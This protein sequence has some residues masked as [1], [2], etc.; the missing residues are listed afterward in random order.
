[1][2]SISAMARIAGS[3]TQPS[4]SCARHKSEITA[5]AWRPSGYFA[6][7]F[8]AQARFSGVKAKLAGCFSAR[9]R[10]AH[11]RS[12]SPKTMSSEPRMAAT[13]ASMW[14]RVR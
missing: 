4:W 13:S 5:E 7:S 2:P 6:I 9:R 3:V 14:P 1:M 10:T 11:Q 8:F 12:I